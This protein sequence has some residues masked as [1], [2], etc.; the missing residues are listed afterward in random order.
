MGG[1]IEFPAERFGPMVPLPLRAW[2]D[3][4]KTDLVDKARSWA[5]CVSN[6]DWNNLDPFTILGLRLLRHTPW[7]PVPKDKYGGFVFM[8]RQDFRAVCMLMR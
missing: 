3:T 6:R 7:A 1:T 5:T 4:I 2:C 8:S